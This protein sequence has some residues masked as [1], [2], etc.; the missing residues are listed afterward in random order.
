[1]RWKKQP[2]DFLLHRFNSPPPNDA[3]YRLFKSEKHQFDSEMSR[4][5]IFVT[6]VEQAFVA[7]FC[8]AKERFRKFRCLAT[9][10]KMSP[11]AERRNPLGPA[12]M[13]KEVYCLS[14]D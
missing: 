2:T 14:R 7:C 12:R 4:E 5:F 13:K 6:N 11:E 1:M 8:V 3:I 10:S 9:S